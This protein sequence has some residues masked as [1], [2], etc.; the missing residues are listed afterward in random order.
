VSHPPI[1][2]NEEEEEELE[3]DETLVTL[4]SILPAEITKRASM[5]PISA[6]A[7]GDVNSLQSL[8]WY[9]PSSGTAYELRTIYY[10]HA[11]WM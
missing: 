6:I 1:P 7:Q 5:F 8:L 11:A 2:K 4:Q 9:L 10:T 3:Q